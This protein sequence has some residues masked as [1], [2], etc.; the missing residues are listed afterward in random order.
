MNL[1]RS[2]FS[3]LTESVQALRQPKEKNAECSSKV[4]QKERGVESSSSVDHSG[5]ETK[6]R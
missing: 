3:T 1:Q 5:A 4:D 2:G 6:E